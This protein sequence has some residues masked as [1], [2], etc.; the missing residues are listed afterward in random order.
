MV[1]PDGNHI[2][3]AERPEVA[4]RVLADEISKC[5][6]SLKRE[7]LIADFFSKLQA[8]PSESY[9]WNL[10]DAILREFP[11]RIKSVMEKKMSTAVL[12][13]TVRDDEIHSLK[14]TFPDD[15]SPEITYTQALEFDNGETFYRGRFSLGFRTIEMF[16]VQQTE[17]GQQDAAVITTRFIHRIEAITGAKPDYAVLVGICAGSRRRESIDFGDVVV[18]PHILDESVYKITRQEGLLKT[19]PE[20]RTPGKPDEYLLRL[21]RGLSQKKSIWNTP[22]L[23]RIDG[24]K[25]PPDVRLDPAIVGNAFIEDPEY[26]KKCQEL[27]NRK[28]AAYEM[29][30]GG[31]AKACHG[32]HVPFVVIRGMSDWADQQASGERWRSYA[33]QTA[34]IFMYELLKS[35][36]VPSRQ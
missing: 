23:Q 4:I 16:L 18:P 2:P 10:T 15:Q 11:E 22:K 25:F 27:Y 32:E 17:T 20:L 29:E 33:S 34:S 1:S 19:I 21:C 3:E 31:F 5:Q 24:H 6:D 7:L 13:I 8:L 12:V 36:H 14:E 9:Y 35:A 28:I 30:A 26:M